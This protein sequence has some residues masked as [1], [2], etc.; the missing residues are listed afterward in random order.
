MKHL[1]SFQRIMPILTWSSG[2]ETGI[3]TVMLART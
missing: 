2:F 3:K 1:S